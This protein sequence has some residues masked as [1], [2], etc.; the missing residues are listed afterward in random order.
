[1]Y[2]FI[3]CEFSSSKSIYPTTGVNFGIRAF[4]LY[5]VSCRQHGQNVDTSCASEGDRQDFEM[6]EIRRQL[7]EVQECLDSIEFYEFGGYVVLGILIR[8]LK[9]LVMMKRMS[10]DST[11]LIAKD[12]ITP[13]VEPN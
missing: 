8:R 13:V 2:H 3:V 1:M 7:K 9:L 10:T 11:M 12:L 4:V 5:M 6:D